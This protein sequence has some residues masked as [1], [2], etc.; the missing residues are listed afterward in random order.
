VY[1]KTDRFDFK[2]D[3]QNQMLI[4]PDGCHYD[5]EASAMYYG[6]I[7]LCG[8]GRPEEVH[9]FLLEC[10]AA[11]DDKYE[12]IID[13]KKV[14]ELVK[15]NVDIVAEFVLHFLD[16]RHLTEHGVSV[17]GSWLTDRGKQALEIGA[18]VEASATS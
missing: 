15:E 1:E 9:K 2:R 12:N 16:D 6:Q 7:G 3:P 13:H 8:C 14:I 18:M 4:G 5:D 10:M 17:Y 11:K